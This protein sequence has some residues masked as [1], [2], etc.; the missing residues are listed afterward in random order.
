M[1]DKDKLKVLQAIHTMVWQS[2][3][4][5]AMLVAFFITLYYLFSAKTDFDLKK[6]GIIETVF[7]GTLYVSAVNNETKIGS[8]TFIMA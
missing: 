3:F 6:Y 2:L 7:T 1:I 5:V 4:S 8:K